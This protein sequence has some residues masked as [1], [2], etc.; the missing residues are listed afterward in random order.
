MPSAL[1]DTEI[2]AEDTTRGLISPAV[3]KVQVDNRRAA[4]RHALAL[5]RSFGLHAQPALL[6]YVLNERIS[7]KSYFCTN[8]A[9]LEKRRFGLSHCTT[10]SSFLTTAKV[11]FLSKSS[12]RHQ[13]HNDK[14]MAELFSQFRQAI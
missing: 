12:I 9:F 14:H 5:C 7:E 6:E 1:V 4:Y 2:T 8:K 11:F 13:Q 3:L 10:S